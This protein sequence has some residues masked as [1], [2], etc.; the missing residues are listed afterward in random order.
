MRPDPRTRRHQPETTLLYRLVEQ[1]YPAFLA[2][3][4][5]EGRALPDHMQQEFTD[6]LKC[7]RQEHGFLRVRCESCH[8]E[9]LMAFS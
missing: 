2:H 1:Y 6:C 8:H 5:A 7:G 3:L 9:K 4:E